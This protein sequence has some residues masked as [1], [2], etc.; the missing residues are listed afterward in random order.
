[1]PWIFWK[2]C[3][4]IIITSPRKND[5]IPLAINPMMEMIQ[6]PSTITATIPWNVNIDLRFLNASSSS[7]WL[8]PFR[9]CCIFTENLKRK[10]E[11]K[12]II[13]AKIK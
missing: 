9:A 13:K 12:N 5:H 2:N 7:S 8:D 4:Q 1:M 3:W 6:R 10:R 11:G